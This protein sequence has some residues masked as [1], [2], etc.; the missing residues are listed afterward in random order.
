MAIVSGVLGYSRV[1]AALDIHTYSLDE[2]EVRTEMQGRVGGNKYVV[3]LPLE[4]I[5]LPQVFYRF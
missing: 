3:G 4:E 2:K 1:S 5:S